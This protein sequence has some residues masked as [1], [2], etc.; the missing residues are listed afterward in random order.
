M[1]I[2]RHKLGYTLIEMLAV[3]GVLG[4]MSAAMLP[5]VL[6]LNKSSSRRVAVSTVMVGLDQA[7]TLAIAQGRSSYVVFATDLSMGD[8]Y[9]FKA[10]AIFQDDESFATKMVNGWKILPTGICFK[11]VASLVTASTAPFNCAG[12]TRTLPYVKFG[13]TGIIQSPTSP[14]LLQLLIYI[15]NT[16]TNGTQYSTDQGQATAPVEKVTLSAS[17]GRAKYVVD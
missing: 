9:R 12:T 7:R 4:V 14:G 13:P 2:F 8:D 3:L 6:G 16:A 1:R 11:N 15:G 10:F 5:A 17:T